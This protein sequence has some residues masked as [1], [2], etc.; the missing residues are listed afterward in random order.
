[1]KTYTKK[2][3]RLIG[4][5]V[6]NEEFQNVCN[7]ADKFGMTK[8]EVVRRLCFRSNDKNIFP[9]YNSWSVRR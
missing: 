8:S 4:L 3:K 1:M 7:L 5:Y 9:N 2:N 6:S